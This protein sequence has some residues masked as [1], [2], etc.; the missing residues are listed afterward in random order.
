MTMVEMF[1]QFLPREDCD[2]AAILHETLSEEGVKIMF[3]TKPTLLEAEPA[4]EWTPDYTVKVTL[5]SDGEVFTEEFSAIMIATGRI[6]NVEGM[7]LEEAGVEFHGRRGVK[8]D[9]ELRTTNPNV[10]AVGDVCSPY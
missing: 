8:V 10:F 1:N 4:E 3:K 5:D 9:D 7:G 2:A 6:P